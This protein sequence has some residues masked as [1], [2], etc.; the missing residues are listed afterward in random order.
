MGVVCRQLQRR[1]QTVDGKQSTSKERIR[2]RTRPAQTEFQWVKG[3]DE[4]N[5]GNSRADAL[6][7]EGREQDIP[8]E[9]DSE[10]WLD[11]HP[12]IQDGA[13]LQAR[14]RSKTYL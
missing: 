12:A 10:E 2:L 13:R 7:D 1:V 11:G 9:M 14:T 5:Y 6:A 4:N 8:V 3:H